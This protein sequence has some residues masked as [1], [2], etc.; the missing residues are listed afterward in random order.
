MT[1]HLKTISLV[2]ALGL[3]QAGCTDTTTTKPAPA[4]APVVKKAELDP[5]FQNLD[6]NRDQKLSAEEWASTSLRQFEQYAN[7]KEDVIT[8]ASALAFFKVRRDTARQAL[9]DST[10]TSQNPVKQRQLEARKRRLSHEAQM[11]DAELTQSAQGLISHYD[12]NQDGKVERPEWTAPLRE[13][14]SAADANRDTLL[15]NDELQ[16]YLSKVRSS[17]NGPSPK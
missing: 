4:A 11:S 9:K 8:Q 7:T 17:V 10:D 2:L 16:A 3:L 5:R 1:L 12:L 13:Q 6:K 14:F 15:T